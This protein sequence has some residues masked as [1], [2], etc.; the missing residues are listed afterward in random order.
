MRLTNVSILSYLKETA[1]L[2]SKDLHV[3]IVL[4][5]GAAGMLTGLYEP[6]RTTTDCDIINFIP[7]ELQHTVLTAAKAVAKKHGLPESWL[8]TQAM[9]LDILPDGWQ[10]RKVHIATFGSL[11][12]SVLSR[13]DLLATKFYAGHPRDREDIM[14]AKPTA[15]EMYFIRCYLNM[16]RVPSRNAN[17]DQVKRAMLYLDAME[18][19][20]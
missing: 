19:S 6:T 5:G 7:L 10:S 18:S 15:D 1:E 16:L 13:M 2:M 14:A 17:L 20:L 9:S 12:I 11:I 8:N 3:E 4:I